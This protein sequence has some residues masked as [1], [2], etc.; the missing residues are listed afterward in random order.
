[1]HVHVCIF[2]RILFMHEKKKKKTR[3][4]KDSEIRPQNTY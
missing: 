2:E 1:M 3:K 4:L